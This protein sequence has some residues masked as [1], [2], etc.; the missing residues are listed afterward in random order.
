[1]MPLKV[2]YVT[3]HVIRG[4]AERHFLTLLDGVGADWIAGVV[5]LDE[6][7]VTE[8][9]RERGHPLEVV[10]TGPDARSIARSARTLRRILRRSD[11]HVVHADGVKAALVAA[12]ATTGSGLPLVWVKHDFSWDGWLARS[13]ALRCDR[14]VAVSSASTATFGARARRKVRVVHNGIEV[15]PVDRAA[16][17]QLLED[18]LGGEP[19]S[20]IVGLV[21]RLDPKKG[22]REVLAVAGA[23]AERFPRL[24]VAFIGPDDPSHRAYPTELRREVVDAGLDEIVRFLGYRDDAVTLMSG[25]D[26][27]VIP[28]VADRTGMGREGFPYT[29]LEAMAVGTPV[30][31]YAHG[32]LP[33]MLG[34]C[35][36]LVP[37]GDRAALG[38]AIESLLS[39]P[40]LHE[41]HAERGRRRVARFSVP[42]M[43][44]A[45]QDC[46]GEVVAGRAPRAA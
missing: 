45:I 13:V 15:G 39:D 7:W 11:A 31:A 17:R 34:D 46:Y 19:P 6:G 36:L 35:G 9:L 23:L 16:G 22:H 21:G 44:A 43:I 4:G 8:Q 10:P 2:L 5:C 18:A 42:A 32:G 24:R 12:I 30:V 25:C 28:S 14:I 41:R 1:M 27:L 20:A 29:G 40:G 3:A 33:E 38:Q 26:V 37:P